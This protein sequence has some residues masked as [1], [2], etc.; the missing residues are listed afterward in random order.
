M[1]LISSGF[2]FF[3]EAMAFIENVSISFKQ[4]SF[5]C[6]NQGKANTKAMTSSVVVSSFLKQP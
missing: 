3:S 2:N 1:Q 4:G 5:P 6:N